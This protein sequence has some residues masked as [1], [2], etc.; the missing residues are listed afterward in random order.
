MS[1]LELALKFGLEFIAVMAGIVFYL[2]K[3]LDRIEKGQ[4]ETNAHLKAMNGK[5]AAQEKRGI[6]CRSEVN[7]ELAERPTYEKTREMIHEIADPR[8]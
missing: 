7:L 6:I 8:A 3:R 2:N 4:D 1:I 5:V